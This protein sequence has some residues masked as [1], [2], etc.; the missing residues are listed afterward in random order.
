MSTSAPVVSG[1]LTD[2]KQYVGVELMPIAGTWRQGRE[3]QSGYGYFGVWALDEFT[4]ERR[5][6]IQE[7]ALRYPF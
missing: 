5:N 7:Q 4:T 2:R 1:T 6:T 3:K